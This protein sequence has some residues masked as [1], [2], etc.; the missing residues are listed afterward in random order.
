MPHIINIEG[1]IGWEVEVK[2][3]REQLEKANGEDVVAH[4][5]SPGGM[6][7][8]GL[9]IRNEL[10]NYKGNVDTHLTG[11][12]SSMAP[13]IAMV[14]KHRTA[15]NN[16]V[17]MIHNGSGPAYGDYRVMFKYGKHLDSIT[18]ILAKELALKS[19]TDLAEIRVAMDETTFYYGDEIKEAGFVHEMVGDEE[20]EDRAE[21][22]AMAELM[23]EEC[24]KKV[25]TPES[26]KK[27]MAA[28][29]TMMA[30]EPKPKKTFAKELNLIEPENSETIAV[31]A[32]LKEEKDKAELEKIRAET[33]LKQIQVNQFKQK[34][35]GK[36][37]DLAEMKE[38]HPELYKEI[39][40]Q[41]RKLGQAEGS[42][43]ER[44]RVKMLIETRAKFPKAH[45]QKVID[46]AIM[47]GHD[48]N[49][50][51]INLIA[52]DQ[53]AAEVQ[54]AIDD[55]AKPP[56]NGADDVPEMKDGKMTHIDHVD[57]VSKEIANLPGVM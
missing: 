9:L 20:P 39:I 53:V 10:K 31:F 36:I 22:V 5:A 56:G 17:F 24:H 45:S 34:T 41:G 35:E 16:A 19:E 8:E 52:A 11:A 48:L 26:V 54:K 18:N 46:T 33:K 30:D 15:E 44:E 4:I 43:Q 7:S 57:A 21:A 12:V 42:N 29:A 1:I 37:M 27:D 14:G 2:D 6:I 40:M 23:I 38:K 25:N 55:K 47:E 28:L 49:Q 32:K 51:T 50:V 13:Y 3:V